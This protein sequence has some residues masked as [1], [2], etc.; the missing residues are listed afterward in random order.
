M[1]VGRS[2]ENAGAACRHFQILSNE[3]VSPEV[4]VCPADTR[5]P[6]KDFGA[7]FC[8]SNVSYFISLHATAD[9]PEMWLAVPPKNGILTVRSNCIVGWTHEMHKEDGQILIADG[10]VEETSTGYLREILWSSGGTNR[11]AIP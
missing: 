11:L 7:T 8:N 3:L 1:D 10:S 9:Q 2:Q 4:L 5:H 6:A